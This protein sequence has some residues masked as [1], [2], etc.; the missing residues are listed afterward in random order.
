ML[1]GFGCFTAWRS[2]DWFRLSD[3]ERVDLGCGNLGLDGKGCSRVYG[4][5]SHV[6]RAIARDEVGM[7]VLG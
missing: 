6:F 4:F 3:D 1:D 5:G 2:G 7:D